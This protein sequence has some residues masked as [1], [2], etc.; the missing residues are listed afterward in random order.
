MTVNVQGC[1]MPASA[2][3]RHMSSEHQVQVAWG[4]RKRHRCWKHIWRRI[5]GGEPH[6]RGLW[7]ARM[8]RCHLEAVLVYFMVLSFRP[9]SSSCYNMHTV[10]ESLPL[11]AVIGKLSLGSFWAFQWCKGLTLLRRQ[12]TD[13]WELSHVIRTLARSIASLSARFRSTVVSPEH[14]LSRPC[15]LKPDREV[16]WAWNTDDNHVVRRLPAV[17]IFRRPVET[18]SATHHQRKWRRGPRT[19]P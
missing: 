3:S 9:S 15:H 12:A 8:R 14:P 1:S 5:G 10:L 18:S 13:R 7:Q 11:R 16:R 19:R 17:P 2:R 6:Q 4:F